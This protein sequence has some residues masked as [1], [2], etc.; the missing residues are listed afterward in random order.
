MK[1]LRRLSFSAPL[2]L[3]ISYL[4]A[5]DGTQ[6]A[7]KV[8][9]VQSGAACSAPYTA[10]PTALRAEDV[11]LEHGMER[12]ANRVKIAG[13]C[14]AAERDPTLDAQSHT[15]EELE[16]LRAEDPSWIAADGTRYEA[17]L[18]LPD[19]TAYGR[20]GAAS[21]RPNPDESNG[22]G[23]WI[24]ELPTDEAVRAGIEELERNER[25]TVH[26]VE[27]E[28]PFADADNL[29][30]GILGNSLSDDRRVRITSLTTLTD[31]PRRT[32]GALNQT[33]S[34]G[35]TSC[36]GT[37]VGPRHVLTASHC[38]LASDGS[39]TTSGW[40]HPGQ[41]NNSHPNT[42]GT[43]VS[44]GGVY[45]RDWR[46]GNSNRRWDYALLYLDDRQDSYNLG[47]FGVAWW[48]GGASYD[49]LSAYLYGYPS[50]TGGSD[51]SRCDASV[52]A[53]NNCDG[54]M[55]GD[56]DVLDGNAFRS[57]EQLEYDIDTGPAQSG[58]SVWRNHSGLGH[59]TMGVH[60]GCASFGGCGPSGAPRNRA[61][62]FRQSMWNDI[63]S[64]IGDVDSVWGSHS[65]CP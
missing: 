8:E 42:N 44:W 22:F 17:M 15:P 41:T 39:W 34:A 60:W 47:W 58:S 5:C 37:K 50:K 57:D 63:C 30:N 7:A 54:W 32:I 35:F 13:A 49:G 1:I 9:D 19:G 4:A 11:Q 14:A 2:A 33:S 62:R 59:V 65:L 27:S 25:A 51:V 26:G 21:E 56:I 29:A 36:T 6:G 40:F 3:S 12:A 64:W 55:Y 43:A 46:G 52:L 38:V 10:V 20:K 61:A 28:N 31:Y 45:A 48:N 23:A 24:G 18:V 16:R 53:N